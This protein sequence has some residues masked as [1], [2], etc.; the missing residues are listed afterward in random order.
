MSSSSNR[1]NHRASAELQVWCGHGLGKQ[2]PLVFL[3]CI[4]CIINLMFTFVLYCQWCEVRQKV[5]VRSLTMF[6]V[7]RNSA[8][9]A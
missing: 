7:S 1:G 9:A 4:S 5:E 8:D 3:K 2:T 6:A